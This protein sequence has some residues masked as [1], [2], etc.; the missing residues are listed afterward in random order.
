MKYQQAAPLRD[1]AGGLCMCDACKMVGV[2]F[3]L[4]DVFGC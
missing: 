4:F 1:K 2:A 3:V